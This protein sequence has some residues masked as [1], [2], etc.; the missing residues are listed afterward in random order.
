GGRGGW[1]EGSANTNCRPDLLATAAGD[2][3]RTARIPTLWLYTAND[4]FFAPAIARS[5]HA[6]YTAGGGVAEFHP[7]AGFGRD[8]H[9][10]FFGQGGSA[11]W[12][13]EVGPWLAARLGHPLAS[14][15]RQ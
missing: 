15:A 2:Y 14:G 12:G 6:A 1:S 8:G 10:L 5:L 4:T 11:I 9:R 13:G 3:G 7:L